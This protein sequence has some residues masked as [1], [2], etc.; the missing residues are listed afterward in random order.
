MAIGKLLPRTASAAT[1]SLRIGPTGNSL[2]ESLTTLGGSGATNPDP[3][4][5]KFEALSLR[6]YHS[7]KRNVKPVLMDI[8]IIRFPANCLPDF[9]G[10]VRCLTKAWASQGFGASSLNRPA[11]PWP[12]GFSS[13]GRI[14]LSSPSSVHGGLTTKRPAEIRPLPAAA[15]AATL[16]SSRRHFADGLPAPVISSTCRA[17]LSVARRLLTGY[18]S[19]Y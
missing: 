5:K 10:R 16:N 15:C 14:A 18:H 11:P 6:R 13:S 9:S 4:S 8:S 7:R 12:S 17:S 1:R 3:P 19:E 2:P